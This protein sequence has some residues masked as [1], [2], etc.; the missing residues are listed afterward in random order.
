MK[1]SKK[2]VKETDDKARE[3]LDKYFIPKFHLQLE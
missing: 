1:T 3:W 2:F